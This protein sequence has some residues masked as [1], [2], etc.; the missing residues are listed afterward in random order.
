ML[1]SLKNLSQSI[2]RWLLIL[3]RDSEEIVVHLYFADPRA[4]KEPLHHFIA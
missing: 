4:L 3:I 1:Q 2:D